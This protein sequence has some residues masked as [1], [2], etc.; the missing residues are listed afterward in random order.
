MFEDKFGRTD[1]VKSINPF[2]FGKLELVD[3]DLFFISFNR[4]DN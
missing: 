2:N 3:K 1:R 4:R